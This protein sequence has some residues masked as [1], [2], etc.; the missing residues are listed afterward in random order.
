MKFSVSNLT[1]LQSVQFGTYLYIHLQRKHADCIIFLVVW[2][3]T[4]SL[5]YKT[6]AMHTLQVRYNSNLLKYLPTYFSVLVEYAM[7]VLFKVFSFVN[8][9]A[10]KIPLLSFYLTVRLLSRILN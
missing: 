10:R 7:H 3:S 6:N 1:P 9:N 4:R 8:M 2:Q 5:F